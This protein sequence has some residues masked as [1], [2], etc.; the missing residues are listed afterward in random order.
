M[1]GLSS[2]PGW[3]SP[4]VVPLEPRLS[5]IARP[6]LPAKRKSA[7]KPKLWQHSE[8]RL[9]PWPAFGPRGKQGND[10]AGSATQLIAAARQ[11]MR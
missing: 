4:Q 10:S 2:P 5:F 9:S 3:R 11:L 8:G 7:P 1:I 6:S